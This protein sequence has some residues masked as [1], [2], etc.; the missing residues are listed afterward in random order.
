V[1]PPRFRG[2]PVQELVRATTGIGPDQ[3]P[4]AQVAGQLGDREPGGLDVA[5][6]VFEPAFPAR[7]TMASGSPFPSAPWSALWGSITRPPVL[8]WDFY[9]VR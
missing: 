7:S 6:A 1:Q 5:A 4:A 9:A 2:Q 8:T 3:D